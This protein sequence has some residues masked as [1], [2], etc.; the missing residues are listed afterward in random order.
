MDD[1]SERIKMNKTA[2]TF[3]MIAT[4][5]LML[6]IIILG[7]GDALGPLV[8]SL[9]SAYLIFPAIKKLEQKGFNRSHI[10]IGVF[11]LGLAILMVSLALVIPIFISDTN[12]FLRELPTN[13][14]KAIE[15]VKTLAANFGCDISLS[16][17]GIQSFIVENAKKF[18][19]GMV[20]SLSQ[21]LVLA[22]SGLTKWL[23]A[24]LNLFLIPLFF[25]YVINDYEK[26]LEG[27]KAFIPASMK[28]KLSRYFK[29]SNRVFSEY[30][31]GQL[32]VALVLGCLYALGL[33]LVG[34]KFGVLIGI[35]SGLLSVIPY[36]GFTIGFT[37]AMIMGF[38]NH[39]EMGLIFRVVGVF[40]TIQAL[41]SVIITPK[42]VGKKVG[43]SAFATMLALIIGG[44]LAGLPSMLIA[45][46]IAA[47][48]KSILADLKKEL[49]PF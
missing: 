19:G 21:G 49:S 30:I 26:I 4:L 32:M 18:S 23:L 17:E 14:T 41:E 3:L 15:K 36:A 6:G 33:S 34:L 2:K 28:P 25:F 16:Q 45:I 5:L 9:G 44:N 1:L 35:G 48:L 11:V 22:F 42:L 10:V 38:A 43:L 24:I 31:R 46:P 13:T 40:I 20:K 8:V 12:E 37:I 27:S 29:L 47:I 39:D 7:I